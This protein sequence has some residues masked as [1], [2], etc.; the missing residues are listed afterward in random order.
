MANFP[1]AVIKL[2]KRK[3]EELETFD[4]QAKKKPKFN[5]CKIFKI[6]FLCLY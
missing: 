2:A 5:V 4:Q 3:A 1:P 6:L